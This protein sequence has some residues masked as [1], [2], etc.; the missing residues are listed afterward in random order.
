MFNSGFKEAIENVARLSE[1]DPVLFDVLV[2]WVYSP[3]LYQTG[4][5]AKVKNSTNTFVPSWDA[6][7]FYNLAEKFCL[8]QLQDAIMDALITYQAK[9]NELPS[10]EFARR[11][12][13]TIGVSSTMSRYVMHTMCYILHVGLFDGWPTYEM[14]TLFR[15]A[16]AFAYHYL[17]FVQVYGLREVPDPRKLQSCA[18]HMHGLGS[19]CSKNT[20]EE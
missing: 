6:L 12:Y 20:S 10:I 1:E 13:K 15:E 5:L 19:P 3:S 18:F 14:A 16:P 17:I 8:P 4:E 9:N 7:G 11:V 2:E